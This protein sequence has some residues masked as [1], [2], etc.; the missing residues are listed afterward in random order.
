[1]V[2]ASRVALLAALAGLAVVSCSGDDDGT[3]MPSTTVESVATST[4]PVT[5]EGQSVEF[6]PYAQTLEWTSCDVGEC[7]EVMVPVDYDD[8]SAGTTTIAMTRQVAQGA[9]EDR[10]GTLFLNPGGPGAS[11]IDFASQAGLLFD[12][13]IL[14]AFDLVGF[15]PRGV[16][17]SDELVCVDTAGI[18][19][20]VSADV[21]PDDPASVAAYEA[22]ITDLGNGCAET[23]P[24]LA[25]HVTTV[26]TAKDLDVLRALAGDEQLNYYGASY[27]TFLGSTYAALF[28]DKVGRLVLD[29]AMD[30]E[31]ADLQNRLRQ[32]GGF[33]L[34][35]D[36]YAADCV[37]TSCGLGASVDEL[38]Q[39]VTGVFD[40]ALAEPLPTGDADRSLTR[41]L[42]FGGV[43]APLYDQLAWP[44]LTAALTAAID[45]DGTAL[46]ALADQYNGR[47][48][49]GYESNLTQ[50]NDAINCLDAQI[51]PQP[52]TLPTEDDFVAASSLFGEIVYGLFEVTCDAWPLAPTVDAPDYTA[53]GAN[54]ILVVGTTGDP[55]TP[56]ES[57]RALADLLDSGVL[58]V[59][60]GEGHV[61]YF[62]GNTCITGIVDAYLVDGAV[63]D[64][65]TECADT[66]TDSTDEPT[67]AD[68]QQ[69][70][71]IADTDDVQAEW[72]VCMWD[73]TALTL[74]AANDDTEI[75]A[76]TADDGTI[77]VTVTGANE[78]TMSGTAT[79]AD[80]TL[81]VTGTGT[82]ADGTTTD[83]TLIID[84]TNCT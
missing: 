54:P 68:T 25:E 38:E 11:G 27:G 69:V 78:W 80:T 13:S 17:Q 9:P 47:G 48:P 44:D 66:S 37:A 52:E 10:V 73:G 53:P 62:A 24:G 60:D 83:A 21:V 20:R 15:D 67:G 34:A 42:A 57:A 16:G 79:A 71:F 22:I 3:V 19:E 84:T 64:D 28:P 36:D 81:L 35:F 6:D 51:A 59:R 61:A 63:P 31:L 58:L 26:E 41:T 12:V 46:L 39:I 65:G 55:A 14:E 50:A 77:D 49:D 45:G 18:D 30:P 56:I 74:T 75:D 4:E 7:A 33:Q 1:M 40:T 5:T 76:E 82:S 23:N 8:P 32:A 29:G 2:G 43:I 72:T 70:S